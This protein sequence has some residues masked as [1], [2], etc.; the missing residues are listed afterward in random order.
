[1]PGFFH[2][3]HLQNSQIIYFLFHNNRDTCVTVILFEKLF[4][5][6]FYPDS[7]PSLSSFGMSFPKVG[8]SRF[9]IG[10]KWTQVTL[11]L[12][13]IS[14]VSLAFECCLKNLTPGPVPALHSATTLGSSANPLSQL[15]RKEKRKGKRKEKEGRKK[16][17]RKKLSTT[18]YFAHEVPFTYNSLLNL[19]I[20][21]PAQWPE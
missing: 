11:L 15:K 17:K 16:K 10:C 19:Q 7:M 1:M 13:K 14:E 6:R 18:L 9:Y 5:G 4:S 12:K 20:L 8:A 21:T 3:Y 2:F